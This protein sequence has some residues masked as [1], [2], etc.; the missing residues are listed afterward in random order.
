[1]PRLVLFCGIRLTPAVSCHR[2]STRIAN[3]E[4]RLFAV[5]DNGPGIPPEV[6]EGALEYSTRVSSKAYYVSPTRGQLGN[7]LKCVWAAPFVISG[8]RGVW[9][10][11]DDDDHD[12][13]RDRQPTRLQIPSR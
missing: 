10:V 3:R 9:V 2:S 7:E 4:G 12:Q 5:R 8:D 11:H 13:N 6:I 1:M